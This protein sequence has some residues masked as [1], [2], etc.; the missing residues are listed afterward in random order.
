[1]RGVPVLFAGCLLLAGCVKPVRKAEVAA[2]SGELAALKRELTKI[3]GKL[4]R[5]AR[6]QK[7]EAQPLGLEL[8]E[9]KLDKI[10]SLPVNPTDREIRAYV[11]AILAVDREQ[12]SFSSVDR[13]VRMLTA[14][15]PGH[16]KLLVPYL[17][18]RNSFHLHYALSE[19]V[20]ESDK[21]MVL[22][23][24][25]ETR[26]ALIGAIL[27]YGWVREARSG[28][29]RML[30]AG[31]GS[32]IAELERI[33]L[34]IG[35]TPEERKELVEIYI[36]C[37]DTHRMFEAVRRFPGIDMT[38][39]SKQAWENHRYIGREE[40][41]QYAYLAA[42]SGCPDALS[43]VLE[44]LVREPQRAR[45]YSFYGIEEKLANQLG[46]AYNPAIMLKYVTE[47]KD[48]LV[49]DAVERRYV[50]KREEGK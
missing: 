32:W 2:F 45:F 29:I 1:M 49:F 27:K 28:I 24:L 20:Q 8:L 14:I 21:E 7:Y 11:E 15:G 37:P 13:Q 5:L 19:L 17:S 50:L 48:K 43:F 9:E 12:N 46:M 3:D 36:T 4:N 35:R 25:P 30:K 40:D 47:N 39:I 38:A 16:L 26:G 44:Q 33:V 41:M 18:W 34:L 31:E 23:L 42:Q 22:K 10:Q 6:L